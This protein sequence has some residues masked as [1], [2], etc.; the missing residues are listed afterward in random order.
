MNE[1]YVKLFNSILI[2]SV[3]QEDEATRLL[4]I[5]M[6]ALADRTGHVMGS[7]PGIAHVARIP[8]PSCEKALA[9][10]MAPDSS[11]QN[12]ANEGRRI[13]EAERG[14]V[15]L[16]YKDW[17]DRLSKEDRREYK[18]LKQRE[19]RAKNSPLIPPVDTVDTS[20]GREQIA[21]ANH[22][23]S[24]EVAGAQRK[25]SHPATDSEEGFQDWM[26]GLKSD[27]GYRHVNI[28]AEY[29]KCRR[30]SARNKKPFTRGRFEA[31]LNRIEAPI[32]NGNPPSERKKGRNVW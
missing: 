26:S 15:V 29:A 28:D 23:T 2:S 20:R 27:A 32:G 3:W 10:L 4:W 17:R 9:I 24:N 8:L 11:S 21:E 30:W 12:P 18:R 1:S 16:N 13:A 14:W 19:Y 6:L 7:V 31:W 25:R 5:T 22:A